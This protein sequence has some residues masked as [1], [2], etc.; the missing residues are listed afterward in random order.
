MVSTPEMLF[1]LYDYP[2]HGSLVHFPDGKQLPIS[3]VGK[4]RLAQGDISDVLCVPEFKFNLFLVAK[5]TREL[6]C[7][8][9]FYSDFFL[10]QD[11]HTGKVKG[12]GRMQNDLYYWRNNIHNKAPYSLASKLTLSAGLWHR[13]LGHV[14][15]RVLQQIDICKGVN[16]S[17]DRTCSI[18][19]LAK[20]ARLPF[21]QSTG[22]A[23]KVFELVHGDVWGPYKVS[24]HD[25]HRFFLTLVDDCILHQS[26]CVHTPQHNGV[27][28]RKHIQILEVARA[29]RFQASIPLTFWGVCVQ[30]ATYLINRTP[31][32]ALAVAKSDKF[33]SRAIPAVHMGYSSTQKGYKLPLVAV[34]WWDVSHD[35]FEL[36][37]EAVTCSLEQPSP[38]DTVHHPGGTPAPLSLEGTTTNNNDETTRHTL[39]IPLDEEIMAPNTTHS[40]ASDLEGPSMPIRPRK[41]CRTS[42]PPGWLNDYI[43]TVSKPH[44]M[45]QWNLLIP[46]QPICPMLHSP[47]PTIQFYAACPLSENLILMRRLYSILTR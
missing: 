34:D 41:S 8:M 2:K 37:V 33:S 25:G 21:P 36:E 14:H 11:L 16:T 39:P 9:S 12:T 18:C 26:S 28:E 27:V 23:G 15:H 43:H 35:P 20:Q 45:Q 10:M 30:N 24:T 1:D 5:L 17:A 47:I 22:R 3:H 31:S 19:P 46:C 40:A 6:Q 4:C 29:I 42:K 7:F 13:I 32:T 44:L 38:P